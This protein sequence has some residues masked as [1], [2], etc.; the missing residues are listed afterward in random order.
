MCWVSAVILLKPNRD[1]Q[2]T[3][4][5]NPDKDILLDIILFLIQLNI[6]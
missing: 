4:H 1:I 6:V 3:F 5:R 2:A